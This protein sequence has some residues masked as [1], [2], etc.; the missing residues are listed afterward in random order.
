MLR[1]AERPVRPLQRTADARGSPHTTA[2]AAVLPAVN[3]RGEARFGS[4]GPGVCHPPRNFGRGIPLV[5]LATD[6][7]GIGTS[8]V[9]RFTCYPAADAVSS[10]A[11]RASDKECAS[12]AN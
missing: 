8:R 6:A 3:G 7:R 4:H 5:H 1:S 12:P 11:R 2:Q 9:P 10:I